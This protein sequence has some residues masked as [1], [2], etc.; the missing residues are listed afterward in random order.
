MLDLWIDFGDAFLLVFA[1]NDR[2][3]FEC[4]SKKRDKI[5]KNKNGTFCP[6]I[7]VGNKCELTKERTITESEAKE[8]AKSWNS[9]YIETSAIVNK[10]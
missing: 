5:L 3:S 7:L 9:D 4:L 1:I 2:E 8:L 10:K 6:I